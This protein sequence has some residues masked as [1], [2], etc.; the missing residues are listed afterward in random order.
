MLQGLPAKGTRS[1]HVPFDNTSAY[2][3]TVADA[4]V[5]RE[6]YVSCM[7]ILCFLPLTVFLL[8]R[9]LPKSNALQMLLSNTLQHPQNN[10]IKPED[11]HA[12]DVDELV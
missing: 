9:V 12:E 8:L 11:G 6:T 7:R 4:E 5:L 10:V 1:L 2:L 3:Q